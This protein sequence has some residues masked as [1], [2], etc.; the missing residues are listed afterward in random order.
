METDF[1]AVCL[2]AAIPKCFLRW[3]ASCMNQH[4]SARSVLLKELLESL[5]LK[6]VVHVGVP[7]ESGCVNHRV[8]PAST[9]RVLLVAHVVMRESWKLSSLPT[10]M[11]LVP[12]MVQGSKE[13][14]SVCDHRELVD[15]PQLNWV[16]GLDHFYKNNFINY[17]NNQIQIYYFKH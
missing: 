9:G 17:K 11:T 13:E 14:E 15:V 3:K 2:S 1:V 12:S 7:V 10:E 16:L 4:C 6:T 8:S 5:D